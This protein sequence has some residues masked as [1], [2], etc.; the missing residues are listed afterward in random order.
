MSHLLDN[1]SC[2]YRLN[3][4]ANA[5]FGSNNGVAANTTWVSGKIGQAAQFAGTSTSRIRI[6]DSTDFT[7][8]S[9]DFSVAFWCKRNRTSI[10]EAFLGQV[11]SGGT[12]SMQSFTCQFLASNVLLTNVNV[13]STQHPVTTTAVFN[14]TNW[15]HIVILRDSGTLRSYVNGSANNTGTISGT[16][17][18]STHFFA[19]GHAGE[20]ISFP[21]DGIIDELGIWKRKLEVS[22]I[23]ELYNGGVGLSFPFVSGANFLPFFL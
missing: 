10:R 20:F 21:L 18:D 14:N 13:G 15:N 7:F 1:L 8:G 4:D 5:A 23:G 22:E 3:G 16:V 11:D 19:I 17:N 9:S 12:A 6:A 2:Y